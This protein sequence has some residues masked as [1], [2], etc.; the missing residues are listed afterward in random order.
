[1]RIRVKHTCET[2]A[3]A[4]PADIL[5]VITQVLLE[6]ESSTQPQSQL[7]VTAL[8]EG[9]GRWIQDVVHLWEKGDFKRKGKCIGGK[10]PVKYKIFIYKDKNPCLW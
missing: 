9:G 10:K 7:R 5:S 3:E 1:M 2:A 8:P 6:L 4:P